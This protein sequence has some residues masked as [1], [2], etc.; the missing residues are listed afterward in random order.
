MGVISTSLPCTRTDI[1]WERIGALGNFLRHEYAS[2]DHARIWG[3]VTEHLAPLEEAVRELLADYDPTARM[4]KSRGNQLCRQTGM[5]SRSETAILARP[6]RF[7]RIAALE[8]EGRSHLAR[9]TPR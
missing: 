7:A 9:R 3:I 8:M 6:K 5:P 4:D 2:I 1:P